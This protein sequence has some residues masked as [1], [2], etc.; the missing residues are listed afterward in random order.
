M[1]PFME[2]VIELIK[3]CREQLFSAFYE[4]LEKNREY[5]G[6]RYS[7]LY[8]KEKEAENVAEDAIGVFSMPCGCLI[9][10]RTAASCAV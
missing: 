9:Q 4:W 1:N 10:L 6:K 7:Q 5:L 8:D 2:N 3:L